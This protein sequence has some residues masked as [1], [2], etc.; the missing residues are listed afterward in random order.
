MRYLILLALILAG[1]VHAESVNV[2]AAAGVQLADHPTDPE[3]VMVILSVD[4]T[5]ALA[6]VLERA[7][8]EQTPKAITRYRAEDAVLH[9]AQVLLDRARR[10]T[11]DAETRA[12]AGR[13]IEQEAADAKAKAEAAE[14]AK[15]ADE[16]KGAAVS[17]KIP[18][19]TPVEAKE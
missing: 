1:A 2:N 3:K 10:A 13:T 12:L 11:Q 17:S 5:A 7:N 8:R 4:R 9:Q 19:P 15:A 6:P 18:E 16:P 14:L